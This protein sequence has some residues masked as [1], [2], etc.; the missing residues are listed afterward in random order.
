MTSFPAASVTS[1][2]ALLGE[3]VVRL[4][5][6]VLDVQHI[7]QRREPAIGRAGLFTLGA[8]VASLGLFLVAS[9]LASVA[10][11]NALASDASI[12]AAIERAPVRGGAAGLGV[13]LLLL[14]MIPTAI[15]VGHPRSVPT[16]R[17]IIGEGPDVHL[18]VPLP[19]GLAGALRSILVDF[20]NTRAWRR[21]GGAVA[22][23]APCPPDCEQH[24]VDQQRR[25][26]C[27]SIPAARPHN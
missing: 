8:C 20:L 26:F 3:V 5:D 21:C 4:G 23:R 12:D 6:Q 24:M 18:P 25:A 19:V 13:L 17:Y 9:E 1:S 2:T 11:Q 10:T 16:D 7:G 14:G 27:R 22:G 15:A